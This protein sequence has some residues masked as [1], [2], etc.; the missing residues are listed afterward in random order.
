MEAKDKK[1]DH[2]ISQQKDLVGKKHKNIHS[3]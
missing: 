1:N 3:I 2:L